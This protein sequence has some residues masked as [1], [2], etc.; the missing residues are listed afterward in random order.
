[1]QGRTTVFSPHLRA[2]IYFVFTLMLSPLAWAEKYNASFQNTDIQ[3][4][5]NTIS[6]ALNKTVIIQP[7]VTGNI[8]VKSYDTL[9]EEQYYQFFLNVLDVHGYNVVEMD[10]DV[11]K[12]VP[13]SLAGGNARINDGK[14]PGGDALSTRVV[15]INNMAAH[16]LVP[17][18][19]RV[20][21]GSGSII[22]SFEGSN[23]LLLTG[24]SSV[25]NRLL[26]VIK[27]LDKIGDRHIDVYP[28]AHASAAEII[29]LAG[30]M[31]N[32][33]KKN[34]R[35]ATQSLQMIA[36][37]R[38]NSILVM[39]EAGL[40]RAALDLIQKLDRKHTSQGKTKVIYLKYAQA[41]TLVE[42]LTGMSANMENGGNTASSPSSPALLKGTSIKADEQTNSLI[43]TTQPDMMVE[44]ENVIEQLDIRRAQVLVEAVIV[45][46]QDAEGFNLGVQWFNK[47]GGGSN[48]PSNN[49]TAM[50]IME[51]A[52]LAGTVQ[53]ITGLGVGF[54]HNN[55]AGLVSA[56]KSNT[57]N[58]ILA[59]PSIVTLD[60]IEAV[61]SVGQEVP[62]L[63][64]SQTTNS[65]NI[66]NTVE[67]KNVG[68]KLKVKPQINQGD[69]VF[70]KIEQEVSS[71]AESS[72]ASSENLGATF[73]TRTLN[74]SVLV[75]SGETVVVGGLLDTTLSDVEQKVPVL[76]DIPYLG[77]L[78]STT[79]K[80]KIKR[81]LILFIR[82]TIIRDGSQFRDLS[83]KKFNDHQ[84]HQPSRNEQQAL[85][86]ELIE[87]KNAD[88]KREQFKQ[89]STLIAAFQQSGG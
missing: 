74:N 4:F 34:A 62:V 31:L 85:P 88:G 57:N 82:P 55:W 17:P 50:G 72:T 49:G 68:I 14:T 20:D 43:I 58:D 9:D 23:S 66:F 76:G 84:D 35:P 5:I 61:F 63:T 78:F 83:S 51:S 79:S 27:R 52:S 26:E 53:N 47:H 19:E 44:L 6:Q 56:L 7:G 15:T 87:L 48:F 21:G 41:T 8:T 12:I 69:S 64:G 13:L 46:L 22:T 54:R 65:D 33:D 37:E 89:V 28:L 18:L 40:R 39:G 10:N 3:E 32:N 75:G 36:D 29:R 77:K 67:R 30:E 60:N 2:A 25:I 1:M 80:K 70:L 71:V 59:T 73:N 16:E 45:E 24:K 81:N 38:T 86:V 42:V 11:L